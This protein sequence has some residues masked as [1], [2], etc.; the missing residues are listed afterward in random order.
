MKKKIHFYHILFLF[1]LLTFSIL[2][3][4]QDHFYHTRIIAISWSKKDFDA[5][6]HYGVY[7]YTGNMQS[8]QIEI[9]AKIYCDDKF[10]SHNLGVIG[11][12][13]FNSND[14]NFSDVVARWGVINW[15]PNGVYIGSKDSS[16]FISDKVL[17]D[18]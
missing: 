13:D 18:L 1:L 15:K 7:V 2:F 16:Y 12:S 3:I 11:V 4:H 9:K 10:F 6:H 14:I 17:K 8:G 5:N